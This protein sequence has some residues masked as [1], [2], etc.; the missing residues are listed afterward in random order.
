MKKICKVAGKLL[1]NVASKFTTAGV[2]SVNYL[3]A[4][5]MPDSMKSKR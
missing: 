2:A 3:G 5:E 1:L 4:E